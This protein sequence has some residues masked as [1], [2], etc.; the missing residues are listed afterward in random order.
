MSIT[1]DGSA[2]A[3]GTFDGTMGD[4][5]AISVGSGG[6]WNGT[7]KNLRIWLTQLTDAQI[8]YLTVS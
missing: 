7:I 2:V 6:T 1:G 4:G 3:T 5:S 8:Q